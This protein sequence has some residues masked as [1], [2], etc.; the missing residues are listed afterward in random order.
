MMRRC[1]KRQQVLP[2]DRQE[3][4]L[5]R[6]A[7][8]FGGS[9]HIGHGMP[10][11]G[12]PRDP[13]RPLQHQARHVSG[14]GRLLGIDGYLM[15]ER[16]RGVDQQIDGLGAQVSGEPVGA[17]VPADAAGDGRQ[18]RR[19]RPPG[20]GQHGRDPGLAR[21]PPRQRRGFGGAAQNQHPQ[22]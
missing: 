2:P 21:Q 11:V 16:M 10:V 4:A 22:W 13:R 7:Q 9:H 12:W 3:N 15:G 17:T 8:S 20:E 1:L 19:D 6:R 14:C 5:W 18:H